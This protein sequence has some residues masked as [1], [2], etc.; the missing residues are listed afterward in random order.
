MFKNLFQRKSATSPIAPEGERRLAEVRSKL[1]EL[2]SNYAVGRFSGHPEEML[3][4]IE[5]S[6]IVER[7]LLK[8]KR[9]G[10]LPDTKVI[11]D[12]KDDMDQQKEYMLSKSYY[13]ASD[14]EAE[15]TYREEQLAEAIIGLR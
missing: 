8:A 3:E 11:N 14:I 4:M 1:N 15:M 13:S 7:R 6:E 5:D 9:R 10:W 2:R 12:I